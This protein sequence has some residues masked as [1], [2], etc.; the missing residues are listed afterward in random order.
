M[1]RVPTSDLVL[2]L[3]VAATFLLYLLTIEGY[4]VFRDE[5]YYLACG[6]HPSW[7]YVDHPPM[8][9]WISAL[10]RATLGDSLVAI[11]L[12][13]ALAAAATVWITVRMAR[14]LGGGTYAQALAGVATALAPVYL[15]LFSFLSMNAFDVVFWALGWWLLIRIL[16]GGDPRLWLVFGA[17]AGLGLLNKIS[18]LF[19]GFGVAVGLVLAGRWEVFRS[20]WFYLGGAVA[21]LLFLPHVLWQAAHGWPTR[22]FIANARELKMAALSPAGFLSEQVLLA[23]PLALPLWLAGA[24]FLLAS[25]NAR[26]VRPLGWAF[27][28]VLGVMI[29]THAKPYYLGPAFTIFFA[30]GG[31]AI[32]GLQVFRRSPVLR[33]AALVVLTAGSLAAAPL[34]KPLLPVESYVRYAETLGLQA[35][36]GERHELGRLPQLFADMHGWRELAVTVAGVYRSLPSTDAARACVFGGN[37]GEAGAIDFFGPAYGLPPAISGHNS[38]F[39]WG[40]GDC[41]GEVVLVIGGDRDDLEGLFAGVELGAIHTCTDCMPYENDLPVWIARGIRRPLAEVWPELKR[42][43]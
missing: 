35:S 22:E 31:V 40:P 30:A 15:A 41:T 34:A 12:L 37:Y 3:L 18:V 39:L 24:V 17:V 38:Y 10:V 7:G 9:G 2:W 26:P 8:I 29:A 21:G 14:E 25:P 1:R 43:I 33:A 6:R 32:A 28:A 27:V 11:R 13:P 23:G 19:L 42:Y 20:R 16:H 4:G 5:L 36:S